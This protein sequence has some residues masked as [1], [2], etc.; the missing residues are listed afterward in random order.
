MFFCLGFVCFCF[1]IAMIPKNSFNFINVNINVKS[2]NHLFTTSI[3]NRHIK[4]QDT[5]KMFKLI[6]EAILLRNGKE[7]SYEISE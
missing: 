5:A 3:P 7:S 6:N 1:F 4:I 2:K